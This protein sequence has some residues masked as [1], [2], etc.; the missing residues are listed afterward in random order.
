MNGRKNIWYR[1]IVGSALLCIVTLAAGA[2]E[3]PDADSA[4]I[5]PADTAPAGTQDVGAE[6]GGGSISLEQARTRALARSAGLE[7]AANSLAM[8]ANREGIALSSFFPQLSAGVSLNTSAEDLLAGAAEP[9]L[10]LTASQTIVSSGSRWFALKGASL[11]TK[12]AAT[13]LAAT[14]LEVLAA[15]EKAWF[16]VLN[17]QDSL[18]VAELKRETAQKSLEL[19]EKKEAMGLAP[20][21]TLL[22]ARSKA[23]SAQSDELEARFALESAR[24]SLEALV[25][26]QPE[27]LI[28]EEEADSTLGAAIGR[29]QDALEDLARRL[30]SVATGRSPDIIAATLALEEAGYVIQEDLLSWLPLQASLSFSLANDAKSLAER[31]SL[32]VSASLPIFPV[33][34][35][36][37]A[38]E[39]T[40][41]SRDNAALALGE[42]L[43]GL[44]KSIWAA[45]ANIVSLEARRASTADALAWAEEN[46][47][48][49][50]ERW[51][52]GMDNWQTLSEA[53]QTLSAA[54]NDELAL[55]RERQTAMSSLRALVG[56][57]TTQELTDALAAQ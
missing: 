29:E 34:S 53:D 50:F 26:M 40:R 31:A 18:A 52:M 19:A 51:S 1:L 41:L 12:E 32:S 6:S 10:S 14:R 49:S 21:S 25:G 55:R 56:F 15:L 23:A 11:A 44:E 27:N 30:L 37:K 42:A 5:A 3:P 47:A 24:K 35:R 8:A 17:A 48:L 20:R 28:H 39:N 2:A 38:H 9:R 45:L 43:A 54:Q 57:E 33:N 13:R 4:T 22:Q 46:R 36:L 7:Q 16:A